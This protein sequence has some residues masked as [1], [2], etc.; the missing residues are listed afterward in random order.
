VGGSFTA[1]TNEKV[2]IPFP[3]NDPNID[4][5]YAVFVHGFNTV[6]GAVAK[7]IFFDWTV[8]GKVGNLTVA[9]ASAGVAI[10]DTLTITA[11]WTGLLGGPGEKWFG[12]VRHDNENGPQDLTYVSIDNDADAGY[13]DIVTC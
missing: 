2:R 3:L 10:G 5:P 4:D 13:C 8:G 12:A 1:S 9:P 11:S 7:G 6:G